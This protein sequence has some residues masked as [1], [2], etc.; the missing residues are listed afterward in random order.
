MST[1]PA[2]QL[3]W[4][5]W[6]KN[7]KLTHTL[8]TW[9][10]GSIIKIWNPPTVRFSYFKLNHYEGGS[11]VISKLLWNNQLRLINIRGSIIKISSIPTDTFTNHFKIIKTRESKFQTF[12]QRDFQAFMKQKNLI[13]ELANWNNCAVSANTFGLRKYCKTIFE[14]TRNIPLTDFEGGRFQFHEWRMDSTATKSGPGSIE[15][16]VLKVQ[17]W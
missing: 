12:P 16:G 15:I 11:K 4:G 13:K 14:N 6:I 8:D 7:L 5:S 3:A 9:I 1:R 10:R 17:G 2:Q